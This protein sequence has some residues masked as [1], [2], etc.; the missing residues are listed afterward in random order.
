MVVEPPASTWCIAI[1]HW[2]GCVHQ[3]LDGDVDAGS[4]LITVEPEAMGSVIGKGGAKIKAIEKQF[5][6]EVDLLRTRHQIR[7]RGEREHVL[8]AKSYLARFMDTVR[9]TEAI[10]VPPETKSSNIIEILNSIGQ[11]YH[12]QVHCCVSYGDENCA[13]VDLFCVRILV[14]MAVGVTIVLRRRKEWEITSQS[15]EGCTM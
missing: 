2:C 11:R 6:V 4:A 14:C 15:V 12:V 7:V 10:P 9:I 5:K 3:V 8:D 13:I 1:Y